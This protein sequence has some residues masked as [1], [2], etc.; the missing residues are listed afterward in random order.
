M[1]YTYVVDHGSKNPAVGA[2]TQ[3]NGGALQVVMF[4]DGLAKL[5]AMEDF[6]N[7]LRESTSCDQTKYAIDGFMN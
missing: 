6:I 5:E 3:V 1:I 4:D 7:E 2:D